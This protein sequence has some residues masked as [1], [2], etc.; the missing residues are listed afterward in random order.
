[1]IKLL[2]E[3]LY[4]D[5][6]EIGV[7]ELLQNSLDATR[8]RL[9]NDHPGLS[10]QDS[11]ANCQDQHVKISIF[12]EGENDYLEIED[13]GIGMTDDTVINYF[14]T[15]G[16]SFRK[17]ENWRKNFETEE[18]QSLVLRA[19]RFGVGALAAFLI[20]PEIWVQTKH[21]SRTWG[22]RFS[23]SVEAE[24]IELL[25]ID[26]PIGTTIKIKL[27]ERSAK[28][29]RQCENFSPT[30]NRPGHLW[31]WYCHETPRL[32]RY[33]DGEKL[34]QR[35]VIP[36]F[37]DGVESCWRK[38]SSSDYPEI[39]WTY[40]QAPRLTCNGV[41]IDSN[42]LNPKNQ[43]LRDNYLTCP[44]ISLL[45]PNGNLP[46]NLQRNSLAVEGY[47]F[48]NDLVSEIIKDIIAFALTRD[49]LSPEIFK[50]AN[51]RGLKTYRGSLRRARNSGT[52]DFGGDW[53]I[54]AKGF[55]YLQ[56]SIIDARKFSSAYFMCP[57]S[58]DDSFPI[59]LTENDCAVQAPIDSTLLQLDA[60]IDGVFHAAL[61]P[62]SEY[63]KVMHLPIYELGRTE[64]DGVIFLISDIAYKRIQQK[65]GKYKLDYADFRPYSKGWIVL[66]GEI[67]EEIQKKWNNWINAGEFNLHNCSIVGEFYRENL[68]STPVKPSDLSQEW[69][70]VIGTM[71]I[72]FDPNDRP[73]K[74]VE[75]YAQLNN[76]IKRH[77]YFTERRRRKE[78][79]EFY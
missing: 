40:S 57:G 58:I 38:L 59:E 5:K 54:S 66:I 51:N 60:N 9:H 4:G 67:P 35:H 56:A 71:E 6:P 11:E 48:E 25:K 55:G 23:A 74:C 17:S 37:I 10:L 34:K 28:K 31:D 65:L 52:D 43:K 50:P 20:G 15:A 79:P 19:G 45:D 29:L 2:I 64:W 77:E 36:K 76:Y 73:A 41:I 61:W 47:P 46:L 8:E 21:V 30:P 26:C 42:S 69:L 14:L 33:L 22:L 1:M 63:W 12:K 62:G 70:S 68:P 24:N 75:A 3:P 39:L 78:H 32:E 44:R 49:K 7:R 16:A 53:Y 18:G 27:T 72:P 13:K